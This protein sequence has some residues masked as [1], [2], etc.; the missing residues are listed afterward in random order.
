MKKSHYHRSEKS[1]IVKMNDEEKLLKDKSNQDQGKDEKNL[2]LTFK[3][4]KLPSSCSM[5]DLSIAS[6][7]GSL[8]FDEP[9]HF[10]YSSFRGQVE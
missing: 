5:S 1:E 4:K 7:V 9:S 6:G 8:P 3:A 2:F 10:E